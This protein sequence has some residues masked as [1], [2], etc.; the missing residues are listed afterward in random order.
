MAFKNR[1][2]PHLLPEDI[3]VWER[4]L[5]AYAHRFERFDYDVRIGEGRPAPPGTDEAI[6][7]MAI[8]LSQKRIDAVGHTADAIAIIEITKLAGLK[9]VGQLITYPILYAKTFN[10]TKPLI[11]IL[12][13]A[14]LSPD[15]IPVLKAH[16]ITYYV[17]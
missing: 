8:D 14:E 10:P 4:F 13:T 15:I 7:R 11:P 16:N 3:D 5:S 9:A 1:L 12:V 6:A 2:Y 17:T